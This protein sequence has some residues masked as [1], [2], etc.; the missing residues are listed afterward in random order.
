MGVVYEDGF[1]YDFLGGTV[2]SDGVGA[3][4]DGRDVLWGWQSLHGVLSGF[5]GESSLQ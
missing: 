5:R 1:L 3:D 4:G 2:P